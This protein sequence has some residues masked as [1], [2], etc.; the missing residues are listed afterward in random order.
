VWNK[1]L[2][3]KIANAT[4]RFVLKDTI[5]DTGCSLKIFTA[6]SIQAIPRFT[7]MHRLL[8]SLLIIYG[9]SVLEIPV[10]HR[11]RLKG[12]SKYSLVNRGWSSFKD[13]LGVLWLKQR[14]IN[15]HVT[16]RLP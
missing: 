5:Q 14:R 1:R 4:R 11:P 9:F 6:S 12:V 3:S 10:T 7:G 13:L 16:Q 15:A 8:P 2:W